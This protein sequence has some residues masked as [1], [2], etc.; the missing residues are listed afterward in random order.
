MEKIKDYYFYKAKK[1]KYPARSV[2]KLEE[3]DKKYRLIKRKNRILDLGAVPGSWSKY[4]GSRVGEK[5]LVVGVDKGKTKIEISGNMVFIQ[6]DVF[7]LDIGKLRDL[8]PYFDIVLSDLAPATCGIKS[9]D[10]TRSLELA[11]R[12]FDIAGQVLAPGGHFVCKIFQGP[13]M[14]KMLLDKIRQSFEWVKTVKP[15]STRK[16]SFELY[17]VALNRITA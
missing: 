3:I 9:A 4:C 17:I 12:A 7:N 11:V 13:D 1:E 5:G 10:Q 2:Y 6:E 15:K 8:T 14:K 16:K